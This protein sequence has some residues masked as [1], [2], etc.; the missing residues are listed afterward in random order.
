MGS[1]STFFSRGRSFAFTLRGFSRGFSR[2]G[3][4]GAAG[5]ALI[6]GALASR[7]RPAQC[8]R[9]GAMFLDPDEDLKLEVSPMEVG[10]LFTLPFFAYFSLS[11]SF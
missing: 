11:A 5:G 6:L 8:L 9:E 10:R 4:L 7:P 2:Q 1:W 3:I